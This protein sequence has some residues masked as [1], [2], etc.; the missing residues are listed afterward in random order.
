[1]SGG[2]SDSPRVAHKP[3]DAPSSYGM[4]GHGVREFWLRVLVSVDVFAQVR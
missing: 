3:L 4:V 2:A 1:M